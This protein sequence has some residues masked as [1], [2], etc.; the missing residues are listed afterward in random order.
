MRLFKKVLLFCLILVS[1]VALFR[2]M[3]YR[4]CVRYESI[5]QRADYIAGNRKLTDYIDSKMDFKSNPEIEQIL[6][7]CNTLT[8]RQ[9]NFTTD[10]NDIDPNRLIDSK[11]ANCIGYA[12][13]FASTC[14]YVLSK[15]N[16]TK[17]WKVKHQIGQLYFLGTNV[18]VYTSSLFFKDH[19]FVT[20]ENQVTGEI[21]ALDPSVRD[22][23]NIDF[24][25]YIAVPK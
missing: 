8:S 21:F 17:T 23:L 24:V 22:Y 6:K 9:L 4:F 3:L 16:L 20:I 15:Y 1:L 18:H 10:R 11:E 25:T 13:F 14:N 19:D 7:L 12:A 2:G 5:G